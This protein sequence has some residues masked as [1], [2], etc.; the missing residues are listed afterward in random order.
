ME[1]E[2]VSGFNEARRGEKKRPRPAPLSGTKS[3]I[4][5]FE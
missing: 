3:S 2:V 1:V 5:A 4:T